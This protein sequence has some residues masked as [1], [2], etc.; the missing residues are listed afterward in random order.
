M[1]SLR[2]L[3]VAAGIFAACGKGTTAQPGA[4]TSA[5]AAVAFP[6]ETRAVIGVDVARVRAST[7]A[8]R[9]IRALLDRDLETRAKLDGLFSR[10]QID[11]ASDVKTL[12]LGMAGPEDVAVVVVGQKLDEQ[13]IV[14]CLRQS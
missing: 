2:S 4:E 1:R 13:K 3:I 9:A 12:T 14:A 6:A 8:T 7:V 5:V 11:P 10:C